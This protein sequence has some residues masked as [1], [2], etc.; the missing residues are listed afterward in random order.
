MID[1]GKLTRL[2][3]ITLPT[4]M[5]KLF[6]SHSSLDDDFVRAL[7]QALADLNIDVWID[8][9]ELLGGD[10]LWPVIQKAIA[11]AAAYAVLVSTNGLQSKWLGKELRYAIEVQ[12]KRGQYPVI[13]LSLNNTKLGVLEEFFADE[14]AYIPVSSAPGGIQAA[15]NAILVALGKRLPSDPKPTPKP[16]AEPLAELQLELSDLKFQQFDNIHRATAKAKLIYQP[17][18]VGERQV[19]SE[20][21][22]RL[23]APLG[24]IEADDI[25]WYLE[26]YAIWPGNVFRHR[27]EKIEKDLVTW[28][29]LLYDHALPKDSTANVL[30][31]WAKV[32]APA[33]RRFSV[34]VDA[35]LEKGAAA[36]DIENAK[37]AAT[38]LLALPWELLH[39]G[40]SFLFQGAKATRVRR[41]LPNVKALDVLVVDTPIRIL[42]ITARPEDA[43]CGY[44]DHRA[45]ALP[46]V[47]AM[48][49]MPGLVE[50]YLLSPA[51]F[52]ALRAELERAHSVNKPYHVVHFDGHGVYDQRIGLGGLCFEA[53]QDIGKLEQRR[54]QT[55]Y[56]ND[57]GS[58]LREYRI[59]LVFLEACQTAQAEKASE[60]VAS[61]LL[62]TGV[63]SVVAMSHSVLVE[64]AR[65]FVA[66]FYQA[67]VQGK[68]V[69]E[70]ML[71]GQRY[72][73]DHS[74]RG[75]IFG[76]G[77]L[78]LQDWF[79]PVLF[80][81]QDD[82]VLFHAS[83][84]KQTLAD[85]QTALKNR[86]G[87]LPDEPETR[88]IGRSRELLALQR[89]L[90]QPD[91]N[92]RYALL[93]GQGGE[94]KT[95]LAAEFARWLVRSQQ[96]DRAAFVSVETHSDVDAVLDVI[97]RQL[98]PNYSVAT[99]KNLEAAILPIERILTEQACLLI[100]DNLESL[101]I[102]PYLAS[103]ELFD[104]DLKQTLTEILTLCTRLN[105]I[106]DTRII[107]TSRESLPA[108]FNKQSQQRELQRLESEDA[109]KLIER[110]INQAQISATS[111]AER[112]DIEA[113]VAAVHGHART[114]ALLADSI[115]NL[116]VK[117]SHDKLIELMADMQRKFPGNREYSLYASVELSL[118][119]LSP[120]NREKV[121]VLGVFH[122][123][124]DL[125]MLRAMMKWQD[126]EVMA[127]AEELLATG[128]A[129]VDPYRHLSL[130]PALCPYLRSLLA[131]AELEVLTPSWVAVM[132]AYVEFLVQET[133]KNAELAS[134][135][136]LL[137]LPNIFA[138]LALI[139]QTAEPAQIIDLT[140][141]LHQLLQTLGKP[142]LLKKVGQVRDAAAKV[143]GAEWNH[144]HF[145]AQ[146]SRIEQ[147][148]AAGLLTEAL[149]AAQALLENARTAGELVYPEADYDLAMAC[150][151]LARVQQSVGAAEQPLVLLSEARQRFEAIEQLRSG[152]G[153]EHMASACIVEM[154]DCL[155]DLGRLE[156]AAEAYQEAIHRA[157]LQG[158]ERSIAVGKGQLATVWLAQGRYQE[159]LQ[160]SVEARA[161]FHRLNELGSVAGFWHQTG[162]AYQEAGD[163]H[164]AED[165]YRQSL[166]IDVQL[167]DIAGQASTLNQLGLL[168][169]TLLDRPEEAVTLYRQ[170]VDNYIQLGDINGEGLARNNLA[171]V[172]SKLGRFDEARQET[173]RAITC[174]A[175]FGH[176]ASPWNAWAILSDIETAAGNLKAAQAAKDNA[177]ASYLAYR[178]DGGENHYRNG[179]I[180]LAVKTDM[181]AGD[182]TVLAK[183]QA[184]LN[185]PDL[186][187]DLRPFILVLIAIANGSRERS[188]ADNLDCFSAAEILLLLDAL[189]T[190]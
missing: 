75:Q 169:K 133:N 56:T 42:L 188:L 159:A 153:A 63:A 2:K 184:T 68:R 120:D 177:L 179:R 144:A 29:K 162:R 9:R 23:I 81:E 171:V 103:S 74:F 131:D 158:A 26:K 107:F 67:L 121:K 80:Q 99:F 185:D 96:I 25:R 24:P 111:D 182:Q 44:I 41:C 53:E 66:S 36:E 87:A 79:V 27:A 19:I 4:A 110:I 95:A 17:A 88:F 97:G 150:W 143:L 186:G 90:L 61:E 163:A 154:G 104:E 7:Q 8:S 73:K 21:T 130:N 58:L 10:L 148:L 167:G 160:A 13:P 86:L 98:L 5:T 47:E 92:A 136:T 126:S 113:L 149:A 166:A 32:P 119:R 123:G 134:T 109:V 93:R 30:Q 69:G 48:E 164:K 11:E 62:K 76:A 46:L 16:A 132:L 65:L 82:P 94:G 12:V 20:E 165:A 181:L 183:L 175:Q 106:G 170:A 43:A 72:L 64:T 138:L 49:A 189:E 161:L 115:R 59:P 174:K 39:D 147:Q 22:W 135:L 140:T 45:S 57:L 91:S 33:Q 78:H 101:L 15:L 50:L 141:S 38:A 112:Q 155:L 124:V 152:R 55:I 190:T 180:A 127:L 114:I 18:K 52:P 139:Q 157:T 142:A 35:K 137:A 54:H 151:L 125:D 14:P 118:Q 172:L 34:T 146:R 145:E 28:G 70:A 60:S 108:P 129:T 173:Q 168:Y 85:S 128:L 83:P 51:T 84:A 156:A 37:Q 71:A 31:A 178:R 89:L 100:I 122:G 187:D 117:R 77:E 102:P 40:H 116:G 176:A 3:S 1:I 105:A 6:L